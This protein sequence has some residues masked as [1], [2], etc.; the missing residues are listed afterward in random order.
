MEIDTKT[1]CDGTTE[2][3]AF[4]CFFHVENKG[5]VAYV[6]PVTFLPGLKGLY[7]KDSDSSFSTVYGWE[8]FF[9]TEAEARHS[10]SE[11]L[12][13]FAAMVVRYAREFEDGYS[14]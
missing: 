4:R 14:E 10:V 11:K 5:P 1:V 7:R 8:Q 3:R 13:E 9:T 6:S 2:V 12:L